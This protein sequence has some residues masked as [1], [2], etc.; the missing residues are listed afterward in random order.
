MKKYDSL[1]VNGGEAARTNAAEVLTKP[2][3]SLSGV[4]EDLH[5]EPRS[6]EFDGV[7]GWV[8]IKSV[9]QFSLY[10]LGRYIE[11]V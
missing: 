11:N 7:G 10:F 9:L 8:D 1:I 4:K 5:G 6:G 2:V 3:H